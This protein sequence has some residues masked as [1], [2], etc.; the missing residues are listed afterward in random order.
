M[1]D[2][3]AAP[4]G[5]DAISWRAQTLTR[6]KSK[7]MALAY[8]DARD[9]MRRLDE[10]CG[11]AG[12]QCRYPHANGK[13]ICEIGIRCDDKWIWKA[14]GAGD[15]DIEAEKG[16]IS[17]A[18][19][20]AA[21]LWGIGRYLYD[22]PNVWAE[23]EVGENGKWKSWTQAGLSKLNAAAGKAKP[24]KPAVRDDAPDPESTIADRTREWL[25]VQ[26]E[27]SPYTVMDV[28]QHFAVDS[29]AVLKFRQVAEAGKFIKQKKAA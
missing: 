4:F 21:V 3:L 6:D 25:Q 8:I 19:K 13:T 2:Q 15:T 27:A 14:N 10:V 11:P 17:D 18:F 1:F 7:A 5:P 12:W 24:D 26:I 28:C 9:V 20:R 29:L 22:M 16:A 23:C